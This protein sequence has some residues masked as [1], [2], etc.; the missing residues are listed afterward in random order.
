M[1]TPSQETEFRRLAAE[2]KAL[3]EAVSR[4]VLSWAEIEN[5]LAILLGGIIRD[6]SNAMASA[7]YFA[8][9]VRKPESLSWL[10]LLRWE[11]AVLP[12]SIKSKRRGRLS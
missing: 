2:T 3:H 6:Y 11:P 4:M 7:I 5:S 8:Q 10:R 12:T 9:Q 1:N